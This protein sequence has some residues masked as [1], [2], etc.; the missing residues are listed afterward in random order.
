LGVGATAN[1]HTNGSQSDREHGGGEQCRSGEHRQQQAAPVTRKAGRDRR[2]LL[3]HGVLRHDVVRAAAL[4]H[5][6][7]D[8]GASG[9]GALRHCVQAR[10]A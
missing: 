3:S 8:H 5:G 10:R 9:H 6:L 4:S 2:G 7:V 1:H